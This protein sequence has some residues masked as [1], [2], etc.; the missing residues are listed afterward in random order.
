LGNGGP[1]IRCMPNTPAAI[2]E[3]MMVTVSNAHVDDETAS[4]A[5]ALL[6]ANG[7]VASV[8]DESLMDAVT[9]VSGSGPAYLFHFIECLRDAA[10]A[11]GLPD[12]MA[13]LLAMQTTAGAA[14]LAA[15]SGESPEVL[16]RP[17]TS[18]NG[19]TAA[20]LDVLMRN[21]RLK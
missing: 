17:V 5:E 20:A 10:I 14:K 8:V 7:K 21:D 19:T 4:F 12:D 16:R 15:A 9:A 11:E 2:G 1:V 3:G 13:Q 18:P 6:A